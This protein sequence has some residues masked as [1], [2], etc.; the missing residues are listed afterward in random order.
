MSFGPA[1]PRQGQATLGSESQIEINPEG[2]EANHGGTVMQ[3]RPPRCHL[4]GLGLMIF[5][6]TMTQGSLASAFARL[7]SDEPTLG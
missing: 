4:S 5:S 3:S 1:L 7:W 6:W 2:V